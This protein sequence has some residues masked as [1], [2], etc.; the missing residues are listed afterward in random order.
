MRQWMYQVCHEFGWFQTPNP[1]HPMRS[2]LIRLPF[3]LYQCSA[4][5]DGATRPDVPAT[6][7]YY[8]GLDIQGDHIVFANAAE[9]PWKYAG[10]REIHDPETQ[11]GMKAVYIDCDNCAHCVDLGS[12][13]D[14]DSEALTKA[15]EEIYDQILLWLDEDVS[16]QILT[17]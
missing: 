17:Q 5:F 11:S 12:P 13:K 9:D 3:W 16:Q 14:S 6:N 7:E 1:E 15:R 2:P 8:G 4:M 10:M